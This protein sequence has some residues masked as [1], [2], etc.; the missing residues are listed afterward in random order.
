[1]YIQI[2]KISVHLL[3]VHEEHCLLVHLHAVR[4]YCMVLSLCIIYS[5]EACRQFIYSY[6]CKYCCEE[7]SDRNL[8]SSGSARASVTE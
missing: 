7:D 5:I 1:M 8:E 3:H 2:H 6:Q 4:L